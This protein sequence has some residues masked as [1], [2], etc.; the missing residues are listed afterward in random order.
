[1][2][3]KLVKKV[4][5]LLPTSVKLLEI[6]IQINATVINLA[7]TYKTISNSSLMIN[8]MERGGVTLKS[9]ETYFLLKSVNLKLY[10]QEKSIL[11]TMS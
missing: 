11:Q 7:L 6:T 5:M 3:D 9:E 4:M 10:S 8:A 2:K 1:M